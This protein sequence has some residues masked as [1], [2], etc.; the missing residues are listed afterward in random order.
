MRTGA[1]LQ[2]K[3]AETVGA[4]H[5]GDE[6]VLKRPYSTS[7]VAEEGQQE[8]WSGTLDKDEQG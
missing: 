6:K 7:P 5:L 3:P 1:P 4:V 2:C 8:S